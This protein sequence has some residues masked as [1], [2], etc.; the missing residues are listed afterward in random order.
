MSPV[1]GRAYGSRRSRT[2][3]ATGGIAD[4]IVSFY[5]SVRPH[6]TLGDSPPNAFEHPS[7]IT[8]AIGLGAI[9]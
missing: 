2:A 8:Q 4:D 5:N 9:T 7:A 6:P 1:P 3:V